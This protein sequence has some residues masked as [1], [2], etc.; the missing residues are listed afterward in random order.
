MRS[1]TREALERYVAADQPFDCAGSYKLESRG[2]TL[3]D[4]I[5]SEDQSAIT[6]LPLIALTTI[7]RDLGFPIP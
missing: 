6:G 2:I 7:L 3:F 4:R 1:L 5:E